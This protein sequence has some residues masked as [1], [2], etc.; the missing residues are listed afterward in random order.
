ME[1]FYL[2]LITLYVWLLWMMRRSWNRPDPPPNPTVKF[3]V[4]LL[5]PYRNETQHLPALMINLQKVI[6]SSVE[7]YFIDDWSEDDSRNIIEEFLKDNIHP[8]WRSLKNLGSGKKAALSTAIQYTGA[9]IILTTDV[10]CQLQEHWVRQMCQPFEKASIHMVAGP[11]MTSFGAGFFAGFQQWD[12]AS[13]LLLTRFLFYRGQGLLC[14][15]ANL[16]YR[17]S[18]F[19]EVEGYYGNEAYASGD[20]EFLLKKVIHEYGQQAVI[21]LHRREVLVM[22]KP[23]NK[24][25]EFIW[26]R[27][28]WASKWKLHKSILH[29]FTA[30]LTYLQAFLQIGTFMLLWGNDRSISVFVGF[31]V[32][33]IGIEIYSLRTVLSSFHIYLPI[34]SFVLS[35]FLHPFY[36][37]FVGPLAIIGNYSWKGR[38]YISQS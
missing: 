26:Q 4:A 20:D 5:I 1:T 31:W 2:I 10:D 27:V 25:K 11:V 17:K 3:H 12:W 14:S 37:L 21:Y 29:G 8:N 23:L 34:Y 38:K 30:F 32:I 35:S 19:L 9:D 15:G 6:P 24:W 13:I 16:A 33:K 28:R 18:A 36:I 22:T 7:I